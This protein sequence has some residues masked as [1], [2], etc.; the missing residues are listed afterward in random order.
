LRCVE[1]IL[2]LSEEWKKLSTSEKEPYVLKAEQDKI[3]FQT[4]IQEY[5]KNYNAGL[6]PKNNIKPDKCHSCQKYKENL[7]SLLLK[8]NYVYPKKSKDNTE[9]TPLNDKMTTVIS[10]LSTMVNQISNFINQL[11]SNTN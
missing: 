10:K 8:K 1:V 6:I 2:K 9:S 3:R 11:P 7:R 4:E 5:Q